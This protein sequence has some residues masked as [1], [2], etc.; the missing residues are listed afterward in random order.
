MKVLS[1][2]NEDDLIFFDIETTRAVKKLKKGTP[3]YE[4]WEYKSR[5]ENEVKKKT[6]EAMTME[7]YFED[8][9][10]LYAVFGKVA[11]IVAGRISNNTLKTKKYFGKNESDILEEFNS[12]IQTVLDANPNA[13]L[14][15]WAN[16][17]FDA[18]FLN[19]R[20]LV[21]G[22][23]PNRLI[24]TSGLKLWDTPA[25][26]LKDLWKGT[27]FYPDSLIATAVAFGLPSPKSKMDGSQVSE[28]YYS[29]KFQEIAD[30]CEQ[31][32][33]TTVNLFRKFKNQPLVILVK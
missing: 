14:V 29:G 19:R 33:F 21:N 18:P 12:D 8:K 6:G 5:Y 11:A 20:M 30:Y 3:L 1:R 7:E 27:G 15:G 9:A 26:D 22:I 13:I 4:A 25:L 31:D 23:T 32:V 16:I 24:D 28:A 2:Y 10:A 17:G